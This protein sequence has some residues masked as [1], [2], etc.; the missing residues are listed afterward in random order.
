MTP[1]LAEAL[2]QITAFPDLLARLHEARYTG[3]ITLC[4][5]CGLPD[6]IEL[7]TP[8]PPPVRI[9]LGKRRRAARSAPGD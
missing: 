5:L 1:E 9:P 4:F 7:P 2:A 8:A 3:K 6:Q